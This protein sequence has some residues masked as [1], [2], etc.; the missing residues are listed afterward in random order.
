MIEIAIGGHMGDSYSVTQESDALVYTHIP[1]CGKK[2]SQRRPVNESGLQ[3]FAN[4]LKG[5]GLNKWKPRYE[6]PGILDGTSW[7]AEI[8][9]NGVKYKG[10]GSNDYPPGFKQF[11][12]AVSTLLGGLTFE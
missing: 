2:A 7:T 9:L 1:Q 6:T 5:I 4:T 11:L 12:I 3:Q 8:D 10:S